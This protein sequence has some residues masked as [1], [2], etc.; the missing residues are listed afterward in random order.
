MVEIILLSSF[1]HVYHDIAAFTLNEYGKTTLKK[2]TEEFITI[3]KRLSS[4]PTSFPEERLLKNMPY[5]YRSIIFRKNF[6]I[7]YRYEDETN[8]IFLIDIWDM[9]MDSKNIIKLQTVTTQRPLAPRNRARG[10]FY[11]LAFFSSI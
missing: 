10:R 2:L 1:K 11:K 6:K 8:T 9:R 7:I 3:T 5:K 4:Y